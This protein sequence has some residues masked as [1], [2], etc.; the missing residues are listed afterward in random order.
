MRENS[1]VTEQT[2]RLIHGHF[3]KHLK[4][5]K[6]I[7]EASFIINYSS[8]ES[9]SSEKVIIMEGIFVCYLLTIFMALA[10]FRDR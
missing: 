7:F 1:Q 2:R 8:L 4:R 6:L 10:V 9:F 5:R 3:P